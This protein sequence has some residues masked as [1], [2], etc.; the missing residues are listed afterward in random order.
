MIETKHESEMTRE[1]LVAELAELEAE[2]PDCTCVQTAA[3]EYDPAECDY[4][5]GSSE[6][7]RNVSRIEAAIERLDY[8]AA[9][10]AR[11]MTI[12]EEIAAINRQTA[13]IRAITAE[14]AAL[15][16]IEVA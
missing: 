14:I 2:E 15:P 8:F 13:H 7:N 11:P 3:D 4:H 10:A 16:D 1:E 6:Y 12:K 9:R 5:C